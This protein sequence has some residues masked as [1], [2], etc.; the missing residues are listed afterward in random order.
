MAMVT[1]SMEL[2]LCGSSFAASVI[3]ASHAAYFSAN[4]W[5]AADPKKR[6]GYA[7]YAYPALW[8]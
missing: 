3:S 1:C 5:D 7:F 2:V 6:T 8:V 4:A